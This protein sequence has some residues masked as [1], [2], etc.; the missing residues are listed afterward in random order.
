MFSPASA[1]HAAEH[2]ERRRSRP[3]HRTAATSETSCLSEPTPYLP[4]RIGDRA[5]HAER[6]DAHDQAHDPE[7]NR[8]D[9]L[10]E[11]GDLAPPGSPTSASATPNRI[12]EEQHLQHVVARQRV[13]RGGR[14]DVEEEAA[15]ARRPCSL[16]AL[17]A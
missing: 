15:D 6:R 16:W 1:H 13:E 12:G 9:R 14:D 8:G 4:D 17:S 10:D 3:R 5:E 11:R 2:D 7:Q